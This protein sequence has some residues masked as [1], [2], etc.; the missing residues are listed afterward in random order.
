MLKL[1]AGL[2]EPVPEVRSE[3]HDGSLQVTGAR[4]PF[5]HGAVLLRLALMWWK[6]GV[7]CFPKSAYC[8]PLLSCPRG[9]SFTFLSLI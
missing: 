5:E 3:Q 4:N 9:K 6:R 2:S 7:S 1:R 8:C